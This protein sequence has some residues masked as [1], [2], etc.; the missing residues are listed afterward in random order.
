MRVAAQL[1]FTSHYAGNKRRS[2][3]DGRLCKNSFTMQLL[4][5]DYS[6]FIKRRACLR[7]KAEHGLRSE[8][9]LKTGRFH[10]ALNRCRL[11]PL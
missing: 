1:L 2:K 7:F 11:Q 8:R 9:D 6:I 5:L 4:I 3:G 10:G